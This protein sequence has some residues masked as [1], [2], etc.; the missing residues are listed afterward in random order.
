MYLP[1]V[2]ISLATSL[3]YILFI[4]I[5]CGDDGYFS[6]L[7]ISHGKIWNH[8]SLHVIIANRFGK[9]HLQN[10]ENKKSNTKYWI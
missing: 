9:I 2:N 10:S 4:Q 7:L 6:I 3:I 5:K 1:T 8:R